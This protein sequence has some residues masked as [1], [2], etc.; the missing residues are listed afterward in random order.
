M[1][2]CPDCREVIGA[3]APYPQEGSKRDVVKCPACG[4]MGS[5]ENGI[6]VAMQSESTPL[7]LGYRD[8]Y[9]QLAAQDLSSPMV[10]QEYAMT[11]D[12]RTAIALGDVSGKTGCELG[13]GKG[14]LMRE[15][16]GRGAEM[17]VVDISSNYLEALT[18]LGDARRV[19][20]DAEHLPFCDEFDFITCTD[21][22]EHVLNPGNLL[23]CINE[24]L[25]P[26][27]FAAI[28]VPADENLLLYSKH[29][30]CKYD[31]VHLRAF[32][33]EMIRHMLEGAGFDVTYLEPDGYSLTMSLPRSCEESDELRSEADEV[34]A[35]LINHGITPAEF[36]GMPDWLKSRLSRPYVY[37][38]IARKTHRILPSPDQGFVLERLKS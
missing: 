24:A 38:A 34:R 30:G 16:I 14:H 10:E 21:V 26:G 3:F 28:R 19:Q 13:V 32:S 7:R 37:L 15:L 33:E 22:L 27:G 6:L 8:H 31:I 17:T 9:E 29:L 1:F 25:K 23:F 18:G 2:V 4:W 12:R 36:M 5:I 20:A 11:L 35:L